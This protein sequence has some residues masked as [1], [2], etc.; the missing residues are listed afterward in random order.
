MMYYLM[1]TFARIRHQIER[2]KASLGFFERKN[3]EIDKDGLYL[4]CKNNY[5]WRLIKK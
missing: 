1:K 2:V 5:V 4:L 3:N